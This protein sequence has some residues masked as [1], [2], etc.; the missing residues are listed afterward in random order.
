MKRYTLGNSETIRNDSVIRSTLHRQRGRIFQF[1][2]NHRFRGQAE[3]K[4]STRARTKKRGPW[5]SER[6]KD[7]MSS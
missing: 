2:L 3:V 5:I 4:V 6:D 1:R 7:W